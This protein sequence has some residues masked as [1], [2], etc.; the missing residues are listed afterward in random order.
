MRNEARP[1]GVPYHY[2]MPPAARR[3]VGPRCE[4][5]ALVLSVD[6]VGDVTWP[7]SA[8]SARTS[9][10]QVHA[11][12]KNM[13]HRGELAPGDRL[14]AERRLCAMLQV[15][16][17]TLREAL[18]A[19]RA[20]GYVEVRRGGASGGTFVTRLDEA[21]ARWLSWMQADRARLR[22]IM[23]VRTAVECQIAWLAAERD[24]PDARQ[25]NA[26]MPAK[27]S[28]MSPKDF[29]EA[30]ARFH[31]ALADA[32]DSPRLKSLMVEARG[33]L[34]VPA[35]SNL[36]DAATMARSHQQ[37][38]VILRAVLAG[39]PGQAVDAMR[40]HLASTFHDVSSAL[41]RPTLL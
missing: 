7:N 17:S 35:S 2:G 32:A 41:E 3:V 5:G 20:D 13:I 23:H 4:S 24:I 9:V 14:P 27:T 15:S 1:P 28:D 19:L 34:F 11:T 16:R 33:E 10:D 37:H 40:A 8:T 36:L 39:K 21:Y 12:L 22:E 30:D 25:L 18:N 31:A 6:H 29:R 26:T 38:K